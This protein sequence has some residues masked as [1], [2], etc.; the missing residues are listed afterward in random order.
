MMAQAQDATDNP[1]GVDKIAA[2]L[3]K[4]QAK[5][6]TPKRNKTAKVPT[7][8]GGSY[9]Y[10]YADLT[11]VLDAVLG[12]LNEQGIALTQ[13][14]EAGVGEPC[15][16][17]MVTRLIHTSGQQLVT[18]LPLPVGV[19]PQKM[20]S[21]ITYWRRY[22]ISAM[23]GIASE[24]DDDG[25]SAGHGNGNGQTVRQPER[26]K[27]PAPAAQAALQEAPPPS[28]A[29]LP[30]D[31]PAN[32]KA[33]DDKAIGKVVEIKQASGTANGKDWTR[34]GIQLDDGRWFSTFHAEHA[35]LAREIKERDEEATILYVTKGK[36]NNLSDIYSDSVPF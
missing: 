11:D 9:S 36:Y 5:F 14:P 6:S 19:E 28:E 26:K 4:A 18:R 1:A 30:M 22:Q 3:A 15:G 16:I 24:D 13:G 32:P 21:W 20:G 25:A 29:D 23:T 33:D 31:A 8:S 12:P 27:A 34:Y 2:A 17:D 35:D 10:S 7:K